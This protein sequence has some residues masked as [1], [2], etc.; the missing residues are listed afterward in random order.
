MAWL[1]AHPGW[2]GVVIFLVA[3]SESLAIVGLFV[4]GAFLLFGIGTLVGLEV[5]D[6]WST[7]AWA[8]AGAIVGDALSFQLGRHYHMRLRTLWPF[9]NHPELF[10]RGISFFHQHGGKSVVLGRFVG[11]IRPIIPAVAGMLEM[12]FWRFLL[13]NI[14]SGLAWAPAYI[15]PGVVFGA[16]LELASEVAGRLALLL[17]IVIATLWFVLWLVRR[18]YQL[19]KPGAFAQRL[20]EWSFNHPH[21]GKIATALVDPNHPEPRAL[22]SLALILLTAGGGF[23]LLLGA[24][25][26]ATEPLAVDQMIYHFFHDHRTPWFDSLMVAIT[27]LGSAR[28]YLPL[29]GVLLVWMVWQRRYSAAAHWLAAIA[30]GMALTQVLKWTLHI[31]RPIEIYSGASAFSFPSGHTTMSVVCYGFLAVLV[32]REIATRWRIWVYLS[33]GLLITPIA[34]SRLYLGAHWLSD[35]I[36][37]ITLG[38]AWVALTGLAY[39]RHP[40]PAL[41]PRALITITTLTLLASGLFSIT[42]NHEADL[43][44]YA[45]HQSESNW[46]MEE[47][48]ETQWQSLPTERHD[49]RERRDQPMQLQWAGELTII[50]D[51]L[52]RNGWQEPTPLTIASALQWLAPK[53]ARQALPVTPQVHDGR[54][55]AL[56]LIRPGSEVDNHYT[57]RLW[58]SGITLGPD[59]TP[60]WL[61]QL[62]RQRIDAIGLFTLLRSVRDFRP[63]SGRV[64]ELIGVPALEKTALPSAPLLLLRTRH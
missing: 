9:R 46:P 39:R 26:G 1:T 53:P 11:P 32:A 44:R 35:V 17:V 19:L 34:L 56:L 24:V 62:S 45:V 15:L 21:L 7:L 54:H 49:L 8:A 27:E 52:K 5:I 43:Q 23:F 38:L 33:A 18:S 4:P 51:A 64:I 22:L 20:W 28:V 31:P 30:F 63:E 12:P 40:A 61:G 14:L 47:W 37:G 50:R 58:P 36:G 29:T 2:A 55:E 25:A 48:L 42:L 6:L 57:L 13:I 10:S 16:S 41:A 59:A 3:C 60:L